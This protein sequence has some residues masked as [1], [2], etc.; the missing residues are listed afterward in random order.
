MS[1]KTPEKI[2]RLQRKLYVK[3]KKEPAFRFYVLYDKVHRADILEHAYKLCRAKRGAAGVDGVSFDDI[4]SQGRK[5]WLAGLQEELQARTYRPDPVRRVEIDKSGGG[6]RPLGIPTVRDRTVQ[7]AAKLLLEPVFEADFE[8]AAHGYRPKRSARDAVQKVE[9]ALRAGY[10]DVIDADLS[11]YFDSIPHHDLRQALARRISD[12]HMLE[13]IWSWLKAPVEIRDDRGGRRMTGGKKS[14]RGIPQGGVI[15][16]LLANVYMN[17]F[18]RA[19]RERGKGEE[20]HA[21]IVNYADD[22]VIL[23]RGHAEAALAWTRWAMEDL[24]LQI[25][26]SK[27]RIVCAH[28]ADFD[29]LGYTFGLERNWRLQ[30]TYFTARP[31][32][33]AVSR[34]KAE[35]RSIL[36]PCNV[37]A[38]PDVVRRLNR[39]LNGWKQY[40]S[41]GSTYP[42]HR[43][44][45]NYVVRCVQDFLRR[46][47]KVRGGRGLVIRRWPDEVIHGKLGVVHLLRRNYGAPSCA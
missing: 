22:F 42:A 31:S 23:S 11:A 29:F 26:E 21:R 14:R 15:S 27:T 37:G 4:E 9:H 13:L 43:V 17:R 28:R 19:W 1:L 2:Q 18:L 3:A 8:D 30:R 32:K 33:K 41:F 46:R 12:G 35:V 34:L 38:W 5:Q 45:D 40:F 6:K 24:G 47:H 10:T 20:F 7:Q 36:R 16:P 25:N 39:S 44:V